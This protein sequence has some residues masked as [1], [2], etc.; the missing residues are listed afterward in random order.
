MLSLASLDQVGVLLFYSMTG[1]AARLCIL[2]VLICGTASTDDSLS[3]FSAQ[4]GASTTTDEV[5]LASYVIAAFGMS[6]SKPLAVEPS[7]LGGS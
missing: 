3:L 7:V 2:K 6:K 1:A 4:L 5:K